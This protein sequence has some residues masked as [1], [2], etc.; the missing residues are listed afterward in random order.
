MYLLVSDLA[1]LATGSITFP[2]GLKLTLQYQNDPFRAF[3][4]APTPLTEGINPVKKKVL[5]T[6]SVQGDHV[7]VHKLDPGDNLAQLV[8][9]YRS[10]S[11]KAVVVVNTAESYTVH[12]T[13]LEGLEKSNF[14]LLVLTLSDGQKLLKA[15]D[16]PDDVEV[17]CDIDVESEVDLPTAIPQPKPAPRPVAHKESTAPSGTCI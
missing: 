4:Y 15:L 12:P 1:P 2:S 17:I 8:A 3:T 6:E 10:N 16:Q 9:E 11:A 13:H 14:P 5:V 7:F